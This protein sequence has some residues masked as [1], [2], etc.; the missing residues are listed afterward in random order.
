MKKMLI[1]LMLLGCFSFSQA[2]PFEHVHFSKDPLLIPFAA[3]VTIF[4]LVTLNNQNDYREFENG[5]KE[6]VFLI[7]EADNIE[8]LTRIKATHSKYF[9]ESV[10]SLY[11]DK[12]RS[13]ESTKY[14]SENLNK[15]EELTIFLI[16]DAES[17]EELEII[18]EKRLKYFSEDVQDEYFSKKKFI[19][20]N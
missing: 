19:L 20:K 7:D 16:H 3:A 13:L 4:G 1:V 11:H 9:T 17:I 10:E 2:R 15:E 8:E 5:I 18:K 6:T 12:K 14:I